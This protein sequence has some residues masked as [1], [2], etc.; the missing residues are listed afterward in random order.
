MTSK[1]LAIAPDELCGADQR[2][3]IAELSRE[4]RALVEAV[5]H[6]AASARAAVSGLNRRLRPHDLDDDEHALVSELVGASGL[7]SVA[8]DLVD[9]AER[10]LAADRDAPEVEPK[11]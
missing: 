9:A 5:S 1:L 7:A 6:W 2:A 4:G 11:R 10:L 8:S 3:E